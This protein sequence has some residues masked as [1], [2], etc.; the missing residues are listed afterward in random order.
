MKVLNRI[1]DF[2]DS[3]D[4]A[5][6]WEKVL[7]PHSYQ[8]RG[9][10]K[11]FFLD[12]ADSKYVKMMLNYASLGRGAEVL[13]AGCG[14]GKFSVTLATMGFRVVALDYTDSVLEN[15]LS[16]KKQAERYFGEIDLRVMKDDLRNLEIKNSFDLI[17]NEGV[18]EHWLDK[19]ERLNVIKQMKK[20]AK[21]GGTIAIFV[22][23]GKNPLHSWWEWSKFPGYLSAPPMTIYGVEKLRKEMEEAGLKNLLTDGLD[24]YYFI[25]KWPHLQLLDYPLGFLEKYFPP[26]KNWREKLS[27]NIVCLG[28][29]L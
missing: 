7:S 17:F 10:D 8:I 21:K 5:K 3:R 2:G 29:N 26:P 1:N 6:E 24:T 13:E 14:S 12:L 9:V 15:V 20:V 19:E 11:Q 18:V 16:L 23:N 22:P 4:I 25:N 27:N 28:K